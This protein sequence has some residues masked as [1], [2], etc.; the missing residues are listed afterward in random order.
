MDAIH[1]LKETNT[2]I[3]STNIKLTSLNNLKITIIRI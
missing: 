3:R 1:E 2:H